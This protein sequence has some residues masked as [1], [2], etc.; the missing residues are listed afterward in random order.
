MVCAPLIY[1]V[2]RVADVAVV[3]NEG[4][5]H[6]DF[7]IEIVADVGSELSHER[8]RAVL[9]AITRIVESEGLRAYRHIV[10]IR[11]V[12][13]IAQHEVVLVVD[14]PIQTAQQRGTLAA[15]IA[16][17]GSIRITRHGLVAVKNG[18]CRLLSEEIVLG[19]CIESL[20][21]GGISYIHKK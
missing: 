20:R 6:T 2:G 16:L 13:L 21:I 9:H 15:D 7:I 1:T 4:C 5:A 14:V 17:T 19:A 10:I 11:E 8:I 3:A 18:V 12:A